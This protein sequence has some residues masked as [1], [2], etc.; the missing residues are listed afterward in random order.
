MTRLHVH[1]PFEKIGEHLD[2]IKNHRLNLEIYF[3][4]ATIGAITPQALED[5]RS[6]LDYSPAVSIHAPFM[7]LS[8]GAVDTEVREVTLRRFN[9]VLDLSAILGPAVIVFHSGFEKWKYGLNISLWLEKSLT[10]W[11]EIVER[12][13]AQRTKVAI[14][15]VFEDSPENLRLLAESIDSPWFGLCFDSGHFNIFSRVSLDEWIGQTGR[16]LVELHLHDNDGS[17]DAHLAPGSGT[18]DFKK[19]F[20]LIKGC[21]DLVLTVEA[22]SEVEVMKSFEALKKLLTIQGYFY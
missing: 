5:L 10:V 22:H 14:E 4:S 2:F 15:N 12:A 13:A 17:R 11:P 8:P 1:A 6:R 7:D 9:Q 20:D 16:F 21:R 19:L 3:S 18:F